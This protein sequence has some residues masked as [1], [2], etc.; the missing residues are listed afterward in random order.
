MNISRTTLGRYIKKNNL[1]IGDSVHEVVMSVSDA[2]YLKWEST[3]WISLQG[4]YVVT[5]Y[6]IDQLTSGAAEPKI[7][8]PWSREAIPNIE[9]RERAVRK[10]LVEKMTGR[11]YECGVVKWKNQAPSVKQLNG[12]ST[13]FT[14]GREYTSSYVNPRSGT[15]LR[16][17]YG[18]DWRSDVPTQQRPEPNA[19][20]DLQLI[21]NE[22]EGVVK[23]RIDRE[24]GRKEA[25]DRKKASTALADEINKRLDTKYV[26]LRCEGTPSHSDKV[27]VKVD[28]CLSPEDAE[29]LLKLAKGM[30]NTK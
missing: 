6:A 3:G 25:N 9:E 10:A 13:G 5:S 1:K 12:V 18:G 21:C 28:L 2:T 27:R 22:L 7:D 23:R 19:G 29:V 24:K 11:G 15:K 14:L 20:F 17:S 26:S 30:T 8:R 4:K 16:I